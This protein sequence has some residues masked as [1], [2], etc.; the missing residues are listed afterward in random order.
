MQTI[1]RNSSRRDYQHVKATARNCYAFYKAKNYEPQPCSTSLAFEMLWKY[2]HARLRHL[3]GESY[4]IR[5]D[6]SLWYDFE[7]DEVAP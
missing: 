6:T 7:A 3:G 4:R 2:H 5:I 1:P